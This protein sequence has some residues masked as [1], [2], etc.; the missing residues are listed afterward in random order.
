MDRLLL[1]EMRLGF[2]CWGIDRDQSLAGHSKEQEQKCLEE[3]T[4]QEGRG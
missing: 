4:G 3:Q 2:L 1:K